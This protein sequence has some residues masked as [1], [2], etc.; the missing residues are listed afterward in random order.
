MD[1]MKY[2]ALTEN[3]LSLW[4]LKVKIISGEEAYLKSTQ[5]LLNN[6]RKKLAFLPLAYQ[7]NLTT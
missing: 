1:W 7:P 5:A 2:K 6:K 4:F 3:G